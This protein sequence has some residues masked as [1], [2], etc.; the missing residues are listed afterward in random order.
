MSSVDKAIHAKIS[1]QTFFKEN[2]VAILSKA[3]QGMDHI[4]AKAKE[5]GME[6]GEDQKKELMAKS[7]IESVNRLI[8]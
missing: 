4:L 7:M 3:Q 8:F 2:L 5:R 1:S 6:V